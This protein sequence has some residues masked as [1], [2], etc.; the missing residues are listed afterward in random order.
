MRAARRGRRAIDAEGGVSARSPEMTPARIAPL[1]NLPLFHKL[2]GRKAV[3]AGGTPGALIHGNVERHL[4][5][6]KRWC[7]LGR[8]KFRPVR[9][10]RQCDCHRSQKLECPVCRDEYGWDFPQQQ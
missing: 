1:A 6:H 3:V 9:S 10:E 4:P 5:I 2:T 8:G 7:E